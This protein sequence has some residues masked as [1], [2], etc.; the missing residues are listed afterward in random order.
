MNATDPQNLSVVLDL[1]PAPLVL[2]SGAF[3]ST[4]TQVE[5]QITA[6]AVTDPQS[7]QQAADLQARLTKAGGELERVRKQLKQPYIDA[8]RKID[9]VA[10]APALR[11]E[12]AKASIKRLLTAYDM[13]QQRL[14]REAEAKRQADLRALREK[15]EAE[16]A[17]AKK[18][19]DEIARQA[20]EAAAASKAPVMDFDAEPDEPA[21]KTETEK[22]IE[23]LVHAPVVVAPKVAG[24]AFRTTLVATVTDVAK[25]PDVFVERVPKL[26]AIR[27][28]YCTKWAEGQAIPICD[29]VEFRV[30]R[31]PV[32]TGRQTF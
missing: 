22:A 25:L 3:L 26:A 31:T 20:A 13:E 12:Q 6:L 30:E 29:G 16:A 8:G 19:A 14:A 15:Q 10:Q 23:A 21:P 4:L 1:P 27:A 11:I 24:V 7:A 5:S 9:E 17:A 32:S 18:K 28:V 2:A